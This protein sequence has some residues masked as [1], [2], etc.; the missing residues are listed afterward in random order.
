MFT[1]LSRT[2][3]YNSLSVII[4]TYQTIYKKKNLKLINILI[5]NAYAYIFKKK[6][7]EKDLKFHIGTSKYPIKI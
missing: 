2:D 6:K 7:R 4:I 5:Y 1:R 3:Y